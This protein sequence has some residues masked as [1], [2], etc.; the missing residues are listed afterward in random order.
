MKFR[1]VFT[2]AFLALMML[3]PALR[4]QDA[5]AA[6]DANAPAAA[7]PGK[8]GKPM[9]VHQEL[10]QL[11][12]ARISACEKKS[13]GDPCTFSRVGAEI[14]GKCEKGS[15]PQLMCIPEHRAHPARPSTGSVSQP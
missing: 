11:R 1:I 5:P 14:N 12:Q 15:H 3:A 9:T 13:A 2:A 6:A 7:A 4:A 10:M 8:A